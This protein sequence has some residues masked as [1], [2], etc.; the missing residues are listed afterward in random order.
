MDGSLIEMV[1][2]GVIVGEISWQQK[3]FLAIFFE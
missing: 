2:A 1:Q 3:L